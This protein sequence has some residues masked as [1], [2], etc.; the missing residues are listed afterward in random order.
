MVKWSKYRE[1]PAHHL[2][3]DSLAVPNT[4]HED[5]GWINP[6]QWPSDRKTRRWDPKANEWTL[7]VHYYGWNGRRFPTPTGYINSWKFQ[8]HNFIIVLRRV[9][10][11]FFL[12][13]PQAPTWTDNEDSWNVGNYRFPFFCGPDYSGRDIKL[14]EEGTI[15]PLRIR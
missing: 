15:R 2:R 12:F 4:Y 14:A 8:E 1:S 5:H 11:F 9:L 13:Y 6:R 3:T 7:P 10:P